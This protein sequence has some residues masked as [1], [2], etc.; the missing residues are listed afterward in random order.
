MKSMSV[1]VTLKDVI[2]NRILQK[3]FKGCQP[4]APNLLFCLISCYCIFDGSSKLTSETNLFVMRI[5]HFVRLFS[6]P[7]ASL[8]LGSYITTWK[9]Q[10][11]PQ[12]Y[13]KK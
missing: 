13:G 1:E 4:M 3:L 12:S 8:L 7:N 6:I 10:F 2:T 11:S 9:W 5:R